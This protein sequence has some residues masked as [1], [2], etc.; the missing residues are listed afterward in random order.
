[1]IT[2]DV[3]Q[4]T[5]EWAQARLGIPT[6]SAFGKII[7]PKTMKLSAQAEEYAHRLLAEQI[8]GEPLDDAT[9][10]FMQRG[11]LQE[12]KAV[13]YYE[14]QQDVETTPVGFILR[15]DRKVGASPDRLVGTTGLLEVKCPAAHTHIGYLLD[16]EGIGYRCQVQGQ[17]WIAEREF[18]DTISYN[19]FMPTAIV[20][21]HRDEKFIAAL[22]TAV[23]QFL[24]VME[25]CK[26]TLIAKGCTFPPLAAAEARVA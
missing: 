2:L 13:A 5:T 25:I 15:D 4:G 26:A 16:E 7:T 23:D 9:S 19:P 18:V 10:G 14:L 12:Q 6:A 17:L 8:L 22:A 1:M 24:A 11:S 21:Q 20:R 3:Q